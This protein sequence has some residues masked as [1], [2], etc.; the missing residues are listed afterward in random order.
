MPLAVIEIMFPFTR[1]RLCIEAS[2]GFLVADTLHASLAIAVE[3][4]AEPG[5]AQSPLAPT[6]QTQ[7]AGLLE[8][9]PIGMAH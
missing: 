3:L 5:V 6:W 8:V 7:V 1:S 9:A 2:V 4:Q